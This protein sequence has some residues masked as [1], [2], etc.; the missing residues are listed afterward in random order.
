MQQWGNTSSGSLAGHY[1]TTGSTTI[2]VSLIFSGDNAPPLT[3]LRLR[4]VDMTSESLVSHPC[5]QHLKGGHH[6]L[7]PKDGFT[8]IIQRR[9]WSLTTIFE[10]RAF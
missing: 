10:H 4:P 3:T 6:T 9:G 1:G 2:R 7:T 5:F 8:F